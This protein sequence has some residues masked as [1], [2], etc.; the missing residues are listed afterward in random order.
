[1]RR[2]RCR[3]QVRALLAVLSTMIVV[4]MLSPGVAQAS[5]PAPIGTWN[6]NLCVGVRG[7]HY[8]DVAEIGDCWGTQTQTWSFRSSTTIGGGTAEQLQNQLFNANNVPACLGVAGGSAAVGAQA[9][10]GECTGTAATDHSQ[11]WRF[12]SYVNHQLIYNPPPAPG[13]IYGN[14]LL[15]NGHSGLCLDTYGSHLVSGEYLIQNNCNENSLSQRW[16]V[17]G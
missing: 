14:V 12:G 11:A 17:S 5:T 15:V 3:R 13:H 9:R 1:M 6:A 8:S 7:S 2:S 10:A 4:V 16:V